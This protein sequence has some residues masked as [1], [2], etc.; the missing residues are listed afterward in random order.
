MF[1][2]LL[3]ASLPWMKRVVSGVARRERRRT[4]ERPRPHRRPLSVEALEDRLVLDGGSLDP[5]R[6]TVAEAFR[7]GMEAYQYAYPIVLLGQTQL[8][9]TNVAMANTNRAPL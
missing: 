6:V 3:R 4:Q 7:I 2:T 8:V 1:T 9:S 5:N